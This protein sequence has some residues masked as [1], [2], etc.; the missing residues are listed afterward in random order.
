MSARVLF[1]LIS[2][3]MKED[4]VRGLQSI[5]SPFRNE[6]IKFDKTAAQMLD[7]SLKSRFFFFFFLLPYTRDVIMDVTK[8][9]TPLV[10]YRLSSLCYITPRRDVIYTH[11][12]TK[13]DTLS[14]ELCLRNKEAQQT[15]I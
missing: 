12:K 7:S 11:A 13:K 2:E 14:F 15:K 10:V 1:N 8:I 4:K 3:L 5:L 6:F 9:C